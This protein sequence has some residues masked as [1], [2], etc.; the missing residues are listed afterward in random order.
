MYKVTYLKDVIYFDTFDELKNY[1]YDFIFGNINTLDDLID[2]LY[3]EYDGMEI[4]KNRRN[5]VNLA[6]LS[7]YTGRKETI[8]T[9]KKRLKSQFLSMRY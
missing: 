8:W 3:T 9:W 4:P 1:F 7:A 2:F 5:I 6:D